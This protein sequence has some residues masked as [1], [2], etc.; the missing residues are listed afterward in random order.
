MEVSKEEA[1][2]VGS[3]E[4]SQR[5]LLGRRLSAADHTGARIEQV[6]LPVDYNRDGRTG[7]C[8]VG[9]RGAGA[10]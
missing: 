1:G 8:R 9:N 6:G 2:Q 5:K 3:I 4:R 7:A 10:E